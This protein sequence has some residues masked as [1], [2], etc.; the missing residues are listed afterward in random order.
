MKS[1]HFSLHT[2]CAAA[3]TI[4]HHPLFNKITGMHWIVTRS[5]AEEI[6]FHWQWFLFNHH[7]LSHFFRNDS[8]TDHCVRRVFRHWQ[9]ATAQ[10][11]LEYKARRHKRVT[12]ISPRR[13]SELS[14]EV[15]AT[16]E[17][18]AWL[19]GR[20]WWRICTQRRYESYSEWQWIK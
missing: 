15:T 5:P 10:P 3:C 14:G 13:C 19:Y 6:M 17:K 9:A 8:A 18:G 20:L 1:I 11:Q 7:P 4:I 16:L 12:R 2:V